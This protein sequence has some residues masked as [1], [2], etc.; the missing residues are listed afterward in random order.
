MN[1]TKPTFCRICEPM[2]PLLAEIDDRG[3]VVDLKPNP[4]HPVGGTPCHK[5]LSWLTVHHDPDRLNWPLKRVNP[6]SEA[7][8]VFERVSWEQAL[9]E[10][11]ERLKAIREQYGKDSVTFWHGNPISFAS[12]AGTVIMAMADL[13]ETSTRFSPGTQDF[14]DRALVL[15]AMYGG[16]MPLMIPDLKHTDYLLVVGSNPRVSH[17]TL[18]SVPNDNGQL[19]KD[20]K[21]RGGKVRFVNPRRI[22]SSTPETG[23][24]VQVKPDT[25][26]YFLAALSHEIHRLGGFDEDMLARHGKNVEGYIDFVKRWS[27]EKVASV[28]GVEISEIKTIAA[29]IVAAES[30]SFYIS[31]GVHQGRQGILSSWL[32]EMLIVATGNLGKKGGNYKATGADEP[33]PLPLFTSYV[34]TPDGELPLT[35][36]GAIPSVIFPEMV[37][38]GSVRAM[39]CFFGNPLM[40]MPGEDR[41]REAFASLDLLICADIYHTAT[42]ELADYVLPSVDWLEREDIT[43]FGFLGGNQLTPHVQYTEALAEPAEERRNDWWIGARILQE[44]GLPSPLDEPD[45]RNGFKALDAAMAKFDLSVDKLKSMPQQTALIP[46]EPKE[47]VFDKWILHE[48]KK[49][50]CC[51]EC[52]EDGGLYERFERILAELKAESPDALKLISMRTPYMHNS[53]MPNVEPLRKGSLSSN[54]LR[55]SAEDAAKR[56]LFDGDSVRVFN[57][58]GSVTCLIEVRDDMR[59][60][61]AAMS[62]GYGHFAPNMRVAAN[63]GG[64]N[65]NQLLPMGSK[66]YEPLSYM[67]WMC[68]VPIEV[69]KLFDQSAQ[70]VRLSNS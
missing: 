42:A 28:T 35:L 51:P 45:H 18:M 58:H 66:T 9:S 54:K 27:P 21:A 52:F 64:A 44:V 57:D 46:E 37:E 38:D 65:Y 43:G 8:G 34:D 16:P 63:K 39:L 3:K 2:C 47:I 31:T 20:I 60:G 40:S 62:H 1:Q 15:H 30:A 13:F 4:N 53:W 70:D 55:V 10:I 41:L 17:W 7:K 23:E 69:E 67:S 48:D 19:L 33:T 11:G 14:F 12:A 29:E 68:G 56:G 49:I 22:E 32:L 36:V 24:T 26:V 5:G 61:A 25:D 50:D 6:K 59:S